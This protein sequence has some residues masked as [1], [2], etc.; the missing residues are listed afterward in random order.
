MRLVGY[1][2]FCR[3]PAGTVFAP[4]E[5]CVL[6]GDLAIKVDGG[7]ES[8]WSWTMMDTRYYFNGVMPL[9]P[10]MGPDHLLFEVG[11]RCDASFITCDTTNFDYDENDK[12][13]V[14]EEGDIDRMINALLWAKSGCEGPS[15]AYVED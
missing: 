13:L 6:K 15:N 14:F 3:M 1:E 11:E 7:G 2:E 10:D 5:P 9:V 4:Y 12:F 8:E